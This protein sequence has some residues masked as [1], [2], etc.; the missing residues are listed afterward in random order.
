MDIGEGLSVITL[1]GKLDA[2]SDL[3]DPCDPP[4]SPF[5]VQHR[6]TPGARARLS[7]GMGASFSVRETST[8]KLRHAIAKANG[9]QS[10]WQAVSMGKVCV[11]F[12]SV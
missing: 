9:I 6:A 1:D 12:K 11:F 10:H 8:S 7:T 5:S 3:G 4:T 2:D